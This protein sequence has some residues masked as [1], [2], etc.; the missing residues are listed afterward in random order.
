ML[1][2]YVVCFPS[3]GIGALWIGDFMIALLEKTWFLWWLLAGVIVL[4]WFQA[5]SV[6][7]P[8]DAQNSQDQDGNECRIPSQMAS[9][10]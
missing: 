7:D 6:A 5:V 10:T 1:I 9:R 4:R 8:R 2:D 3:A